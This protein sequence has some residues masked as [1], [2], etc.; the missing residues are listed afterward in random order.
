MFTN[1]DSLPPISKIESLD[2]FSVNVVD[3]ELDIE[4]SDDEIPQIHYKISNKLKASAEL[5]RT[6]PIEFGEYPQLSRSSD[7]PDI[8]PSPKSQW[9]P[10]DAVEECLECSSKFTMVSRRHHCRSCGNALPIKK[11]FDQKK[12]Q[13]FCSECSKFMANVA[14]GGKVR[15]CK[16]CFQASSS[17]IQSSFLTF[18]C[19]NKMKKWREFIDSN[20]KS[21]VEGEFS[22]SLYKYKFQQCQL[23]N[24]QFVTKATGGRTEK[25][26]TDNL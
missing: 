11:F 10:D 9:M 17:D 3:L 8:S 12:G 25:C 16:I 22:S 18:Y 13:L 7:G 5:S 4:D 24:G 15:V 6:P 19:T 20:D 1:P 21:W 14:L 2:D 23:T 26:V